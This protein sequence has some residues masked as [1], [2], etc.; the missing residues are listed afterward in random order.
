MGCSPYSAVRKGHKE[1]LDLASRLMGY[2][3]ITSVIWRKRARLKWPLAKKGATERAATESRISARK[4]R[5]KQRHFS[6]KQRY[7]RATA[8]CV[9]KTSSNTPEFAG[10]RW[11]TWRRLVSSSSPSANLAKA[12]LLPTLAPH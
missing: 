7:V 8:L 10:L 9:P 2:Q 1:A 3:Q 4:F 11:L 5:W 12:R 6:Q